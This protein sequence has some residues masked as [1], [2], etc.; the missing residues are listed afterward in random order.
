MRVIYKVVTVAVLA[1]LV[2]Y[3]GQ[4]YGA[5]QTSLMDKYIQN[6]D[7]DAKSLQKFAEKGLAKA[8]HKITA[9]TE[10]IIA[11]EKEPSK[12]IQQPRKANNIS[13]RL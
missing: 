4:D 11:E 5:K 7:K 9:E 3:S 10:K 6:A 2:C 12:N 1:G 13:K 8:K